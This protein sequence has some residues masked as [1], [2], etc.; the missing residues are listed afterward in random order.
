MLGLSDLQLAISNLWDEFGSTDNIG[1]A[2]VINGG[3]AAIGVIAWLALD[4]VAA[5]A[6]LVW[7]IINLSGILKW[8]FRL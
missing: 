2:L 3:L 6:G 1:L 7:A 4:G 8:V 5:Y